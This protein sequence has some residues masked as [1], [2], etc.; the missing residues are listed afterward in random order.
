L[1]TEIKPQ[2]NVSGMVSDAY[3]EK[4]ENESPF[5]RIQ[6]QLRKDALE[7]IEM[8]SY[9]QTLTSYV[10]STRN[11]VQQLINLLPADIREAIHAIPEARDELNE[12]VMDTGKPVL[13][14]FFDQKGQRI[15]YPLNQI[16]RHV[17][18]KQI[19]ANLRFSS[20]NRAGVDGC[21]HRISRIQSRTCRTVGLTIRVGRA[22]VPGQGVAQLIQDMLISGKK[23]ILI[24]GKPGTGKTHTLRDICC[25]LAAAGHRVVIID[26]SNE[27][28]GEGDAPHISL[29]QC[30]RIQVQNRA[31]QRT[32]LVEA[33]QNHT[34]DI[35]VV[36]EIGTKE[37]V[38]AV[39][40]VIT[41]V[42][43]MVATVHGSFTSILLNPVLRDLLGG[44]AINTIGD[45]AAGKSASKKKTRTERAGVPVFP[46]VVELVSRTEVLVYDD[47][48]QIIDDLLKPG[49]VP[50]VERRWLESPG[51]VA[52]LDDKEKKFMVRQEKLE[53]FDKALGF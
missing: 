32:H 38:R 29:N 40:E 47:V 43:S 44:L 16:V 45:L 26:T 3:C 34:P 39:K 12:I 31:A 30:R 17:D 23:S 27:V 7:F 1:F 14:Y 24:A 37:E 8:T 5:F 52:S 33:T 20:D 18:L 42:N 25:Q 21:L 41:R 2:M 36:D 51:S 9:S 4:P 15:A 22:C 13:L 11:E 50:L 6:Q 10:E 49:I 46:T 28:G 48:G 35:L 19:C 53:K